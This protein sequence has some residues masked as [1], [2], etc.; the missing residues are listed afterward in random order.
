MYIQCVNVCV[1]VRVC[2][3][4][5][6]CVLCACVCVCACVCTCAV[7]VCARACV[8]VRMNITNPQHPPASVVGT[9]R[10]EVEWNVSLSHTLIMLM[11]T[12]HA[13]YKLAG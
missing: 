4:V 1:C 2:V 3:C 7:C 10:E 9:A 8:C 6:V 13:K 12:R 11:S 5:C